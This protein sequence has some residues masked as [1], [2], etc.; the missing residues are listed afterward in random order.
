[1]Y[2]NRIYI[3]EPTPRTDRPMTKYIATEGEGFG[4]RLAA[5]RKAAG[6]T[7]EQ[8]ASELGISRRRIAYY[9]AESDHPPVGFLADLARVLSTTTDALLG[10]GAG[11]TKTRSVSLSPRLERRL[12]QIERLSPKPKQ[13]LLSIIDSFIA[14]EEH[15]IQ[16]GRSQG[17]R[18]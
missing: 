10:H 15:R 18:S 11:K 12:K 17:S 13:Q 2:E 5:L 6:Y 1:M 16:G 4:S 8:L 7:Q 14:A 3:P 9:E